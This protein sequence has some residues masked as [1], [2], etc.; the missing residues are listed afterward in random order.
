MEVDAK[1]IEQLGARVEDA[2]AFLH[3]EDKIAELAKLDEE[4][5]QPGF[6]DDTAHAQAVS[7]RAGNLRETIREYEGEIGRA[8]V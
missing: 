6:W 4:T 3:V 5:A 7:K 1:T 2:R 8:H